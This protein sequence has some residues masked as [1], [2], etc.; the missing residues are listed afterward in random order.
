MNEADTAQYTPGLVGRALAELQERNRN[1][2]L[3]LAQA[4]DALE[5]HRD[6]MVREIDRVL[7]SE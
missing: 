4:R 6:P 3:C 7:N 2:R 1:F 5:R